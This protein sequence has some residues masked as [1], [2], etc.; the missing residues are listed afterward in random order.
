MLRSAQ[1]MNGSATRG[2]LDDE[3]PSDADSVE[4][5]SRVVVLQKTV[6]GECVEKRGDVLQLEHEEQHRDREPVGGEDPEESALPK[7]QELGRRL[8]VEMGTYVGPVQQE[9]RD[10][11]E[12]A[13]TERPQPGDPVGERALVP[14]RLELADDVVDDDRQRGDRP[15]TVEARK[16]VRRPRAAAPCRRYGGPESGGRHG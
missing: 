13:H 5:V 12:D 15:Q 9:P 6:R 3:R 2:Y 16:A 8:T 1:A 14:G 11:E 10:Q 7:R 4:L